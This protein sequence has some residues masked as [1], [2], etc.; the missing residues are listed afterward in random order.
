MILA[1]ARTVLLEA[2]R[3]PFAW[4]SVTTILLLA[5][6]SRLFL[7][8]SFGQDQAEARYLVACSLFLAGFTFACFQ[9]TGQIRRDLDRGTLGL[10]LSKPLTRGEYVI[11][12]WLGNF[13]TAALLSTAVGL[14]VLLLVHPAAGTSPLPIVTTD[15]LAAAARSLVA[16]GLLL[17]LAV[18]LSVALPHSLAPPAFLLLFLAGTLI[19]GRILP[20]LGLLGLD[21]GVRPPWRPFLAYAG[22]LTA[23]FLSLTY[24]S[25]G[26]RAPLRSPS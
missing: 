24:T 23:G 13:A 7:A 20:D 17:S 6:A 19:R 11:G 4:I 3:R 5:F 21:P 1:L 25:L 10:L 26:F 18:F 14:G 8:F 12:V 22:L 16:L 15:L 2:L 9:G